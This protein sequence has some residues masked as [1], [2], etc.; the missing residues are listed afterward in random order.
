MPQTNGL[1]NEELVALRALQR[2]G[3]APVAEDPIWDY[4]VSANLV[5]IDREVHPHRARLTP[6]GRA[7][8]VGE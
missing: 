7:Y 1:S 6:E 4:L 5:W 2:E 3:D 8:L